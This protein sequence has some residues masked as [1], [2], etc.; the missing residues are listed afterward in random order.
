MIGLLVSVGVT[1]DYTS[2]ISYHYF[3]DQLPPDATI[4]DSIDRLRYAK[5][6]FMLF[7]QVP[8]FWPI[9]VRLGYCNARWLVRSRIV[10]KT[11]NIYSRRLYESSGVPTLQGIVSC[12]C[13]LLPLIIFDAFAKMMRMKIDL[14]TIK[15]YSPIPEGK[16]LT[17]F[18]PSK[19]VANILQK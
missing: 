3:I 13:G 17:N 15:F 19:N 8:Y 16:F 6:Y 9:R 1:V 10:F 11:C 7:S 14:L 12:A 5:E 18:N 4:E 2:H